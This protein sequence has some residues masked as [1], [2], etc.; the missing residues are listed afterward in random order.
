MLNLKRET[1]MVSGGAGFIGSHVVERLLNS[2][3]VE[4]VVVVDN[5]FLGKEENLSLVAES[6]RVITYRLDASDI[7]SMKDVVEENG[8]ELVI[9]MA[10]IPLVTSLKFPHMT[11]QTNISIALAFCELLRNGAIRRLVHVSSSEAYGSAQYI[12][13]DEKH[14]HA[15]ITP[16]AASKAAADQIIQS[17]VKTFGLD[18]AIIRPFNNFGPRQNAGSYA[19]VIPI[20]VGKVFAGEP[21][22]VFGDGQQTRDFSFVRDTAQA[23]VDLAF[24]DTTPG[25]SYNLATG[26]EIDINSLI[27]KILKVMNAPSHQINHVRARPG[28]VRRHCADVKLATSLLGYALPSLGEEQLAETVNWYVG[29]RRAT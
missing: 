27:E 10:V 14:P 3:Q 18:A 8:V 20:V 21:I 13:M 9:D 5:F 12:P 1:V 17:Y 22:E 2:P 19:G 26:V 11:V 6:G 28:D 15:A 16:Y 25:E 23:I 4:K 24:A 7:Q 29:Q